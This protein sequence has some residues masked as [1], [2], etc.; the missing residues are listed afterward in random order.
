VCPTLYD[1]MGCSPPG[2]SVHG[3]SQT[4]IL[5]WVAIS[6]SGEFSRPRDQTYISCIGRQILYQWAT[7]EAQ[8]QAHS[9]SPSYLKSINQAANQSPCLGLLWF[10]CLHPLRSGFQILKCPVVGVACP[11]KCLLIIAKQH[12]W[13]SFFPKPLSKVIPFFPSCRRKDRYRETAVFL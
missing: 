8:R 4:R 1:P 9:K 10:S 12:P 6:S 11:P 13:V 3:I 5:E 7:W 2:S